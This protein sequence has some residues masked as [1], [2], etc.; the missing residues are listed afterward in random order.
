MARSVIHD[1][2]VFL[3]TD[4]EMFNYLSILQPHYFFHLNLKITDRHI[5]S[6]YC[7]ILIND[8]ILAHVPKGTICNSVFF[9]SNIIKHALQR[10]KKINIS[11]I[12]STSAQLHQLWWSWQNEVIFPHTIFGPEQGGW[13]H[14]RRVWLIAVRQNYSLL[15]LTSLNMLAELLSSKTRTLLI[16]GH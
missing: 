5:Y 14:I 16:I 2:S 3:L 10:K 9:F 8:S 1:G 13:G 12:N 7:P 6:E 11:L 15:W 4:W